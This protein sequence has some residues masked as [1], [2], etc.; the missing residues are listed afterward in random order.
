V[1]GAAFTRAGLAAMSGLDAT[2]LEALL[3]PLVHRELLEYES[4]PRSPERGQYR[5]V[6]S[7]IR[8]VAY[9]RLTREERRTR[10]VRAAEFFSELEEA[11]LAGAAASHFMAA[12]DLTED[13]GNVLAAKV[14]SAL[15]EAADHAARVHSHA[16]GLAM[17]E[18]ALALTTDPSEEP[19]LLHQAA[20]AASALA[21]HDLAVDYARSALRWHERRGDARGRVS[22]AA[23][24]GDVLCS[25]FDPEEAIAVLE[26]VLE[27]ER[28][29]REPASVAAGATLARAYLM[30]LR[31]ADAA[32]MADRVIGP[33]ERLDLIPAIVDTLIT[34]GTALGDLGRMHEAITL[35]RGAGKYADAHDL[36]V[37]HMRAIN[38]LGHLLAFDDHPAAMKACRTGM[39]L[40][41]R[42]GDVRFAG[43][44][45][46]AV[47]AYDE[48]DGKFLEARELR[49]DVRDRFELPP[50]TALWYDLTDLTA[51]V[52]Q[53]EASAIS[54]AYEA[55]SRAG[56]DADPQTQAAVPAARARLDIL[57]KRFAEAYEGV[58][59]VDI[60][61]RFLD[62]YTIAT[63]AAALLRDDDRL[64]AVAEAVAAN[65]AR[66]RM[67]RAVADTISGAR[68]ALRGQTAQ[69]VVDFNRALAARHLRLDRAHLQ[70]LFAT[71]VGRDVPDAR[72]A[73]DA[74]FE[75]FSRVGA[76]A[77]VDVYSDGMPPASARRAAGG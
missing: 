30:A 36:P 74:A 38:N 24:L 50:S 40:A 59:S 64:E 43:S 21:R 45:A 20:R 69:A 58:M 54:A 73:S 60:A 44:F 29:F 3:E 42:L 52:E 25:A 33:A 47:A 66:G 23:L 19:R 55:V 31:D 12:R 4:D 32:E 62:H 27:G 76:T 37:A 34:R 17:V 70:A 6:Q 2:R 75:V 56:H 46:W 28:T 10:H 51:R 8:E 18:Q 7:M 49:D 72:T 16:Q 39:A 53:G 11:E 14:T 77:Y 15:T 22:A 1:L 5:F 57:T 9:A 71:V 48:R 13:P 65:P 63:G 35:L 61:H 41:N 68:A 67:L 26:P